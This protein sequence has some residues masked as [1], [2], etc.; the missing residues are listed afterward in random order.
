MEM[1]DRLLGVDP[2]DVI[3]EIGCG[4]GRV[5]K[6]MGPRCSKWIG[7][8]ISR[9]MLNVAALRL[10]GVPNI[11]LVELS[12]VGLREIP[13]ESV[14]LVYS[15]VV[16]MHLYEWDRFRYVKEAFRVLR[17][18][19]RCFFDNV[20]ITSTH[21]WRVFLDGYALDPDKR[22]SHL[23][24]VSSGDELRTYGVKAGFTEVVVHRWDDAWVGITGLK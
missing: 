15:T 6:Y 8:D 21:G 24:M 11:Q 10:R 4:V 13:D 23:S 5:G 2:T 17:P 14:S 3:L 1:I 12:S 19:G 7:T 22:P 20:D 9:G 18:G 16:F